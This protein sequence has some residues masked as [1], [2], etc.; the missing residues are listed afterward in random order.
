M[1]AK[2]QKNVAWRD[3]KCHVIGEALRLAL[4][5]M[6]M[7]KFRWRFEIHQKKKDLKMM[8]APAYRNSH[9]PVKNCMFTA[10]SGNK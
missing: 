6:T 5:M 7:M 1:Q 2:K 10:E 3:M 8:L 9:L 4:D